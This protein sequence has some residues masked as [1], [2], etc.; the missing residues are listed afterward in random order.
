MVAERFAP[1]PVCGLKVNAQKLGKHLANVHPLE[2]PPEAVDSYLRTVE[3]AKARRRVFK[4]V[5]G[6]IKPNVEFGRRNQQGMPA[7]EFEDPR[8]MLWQNGG[9]ETASFEEP[10]LL[11]Y[12]GSLPA[13]PQAVRVELSTQKSDAKNLATCGLGCRAYSE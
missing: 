8:K 7:L 1:C 10:K 4:P 5:A 2:A 11:H 12:A 9:I 3:E 6:Q 13:A